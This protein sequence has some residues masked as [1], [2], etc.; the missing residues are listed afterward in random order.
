[1]GHTPALRQHS[2]IPPEHQPHGQPS[3]PGVRA[4][5]RAGGELLD[6]VLSSILSPTCTSF[7][8]S[9]GRAAG[10]IWAVVGLAFRNAF[11]IGL[12]SSSALPN[13]EDAA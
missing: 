6:Q 2:H 10:E 12:E 7:C 1:M 5:S 9:A 8:L 11:R 4:V 3:T 13:P